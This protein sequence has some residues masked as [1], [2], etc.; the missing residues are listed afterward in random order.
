M[1]FLIG[2][3]LN[4]KLIVG[5]YKLKISELSLRR[6]SLVLSTQN[7]PYAILHEK[8]KLIVHWILAVAGQFIPKISDWANPQAKG[9]HG[10]PGVLWAFALFCS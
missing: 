3:Q 2:S 1:Q 8:S 5:K 10:P 4:F 6:S 9:G 7:I